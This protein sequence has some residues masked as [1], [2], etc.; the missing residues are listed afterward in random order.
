[1]RAASTITMGTD[2]QN[3]YLVTGDTDGNLAVWELAQYALVESASENSVLR[4]EPR[5]LSSPLAAHTYI[6]RLFTHCY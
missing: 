1:M 4:K 5:A 6:H 3:E 2:A